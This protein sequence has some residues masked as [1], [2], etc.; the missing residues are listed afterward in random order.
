MLQLVSLLLLHATVSASPAPAQ[1]PLSALTPAAYFDP[2]PGGGSMLDDAGNG[3]GEPLN[4][5]VPGREAICSSGLTRGQVIISGLSA[6]GV[7]TDTGLI[8]YARAI[9]L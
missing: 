3:L 8:N 5:R 9:G 4:V 6:P 2:A 7:L 1:I